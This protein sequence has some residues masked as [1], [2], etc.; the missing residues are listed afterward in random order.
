M[1]GLDAATISSRY[2]CVDFSKKIGFLNIFPKNAYF[3]SIGSKF[4]GE[5][6]NLNLEHV[7]KFHDSVIVS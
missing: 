2:A 1:R 4:D 7:S 6:L 3:L 5:D